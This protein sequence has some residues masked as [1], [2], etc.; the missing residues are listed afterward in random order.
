F[1]KDVAV[2]WDAFDVLRLDEYGTFEIKGRV[3]GTDIQAVAKVIV[4]G[5]VGVESFSLVTPK[6]KSFKLPF[7]AK[8]YHNT[9]RVDE[10]NVVWEAFDK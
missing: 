3:E 7:K 8:A 5:Y 4:E 6:D 9:G 10:F 1:D 2:T